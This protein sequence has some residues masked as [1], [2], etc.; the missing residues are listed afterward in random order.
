MGGGG[1]AYAAMFGS[2]ITN[3]RSHTI[4]MLQS[5]LWLTLCL[6]GPYFVNPGWISILQKQIG[7]ATELNGQDTASPQLS[8]QHLPTET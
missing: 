5:A 1:Y 6:T 2:Y 3:G 8:K 4:A 7:H